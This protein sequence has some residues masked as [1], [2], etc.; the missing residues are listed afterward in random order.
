MQ[1]SKANWRLHASVRGRNNASSC[2]NTC[3]DHVVWR[4]VCYIFIDLINTRLEATNN[5]R[6][7]I[8]VSTILDGSKYFAQG[9]WRPIT[10]TCTTNIVSI[11]TTV[12]L[13]K[14]NNHFAVG[15][16]GE[17]GRGESGGRGDAAPSRNGQE[18][19]GGQLGTPKNPKKNTHINILSNIQ[20]R[21]VSL[22]RRKWL[23][24]NDL[25]PSGWEDETR[26]R[27]WMHAAMVC[28]PRQPPSAACGHV[29]AERGIPHTSLPPTP[30]KSPRS[31]HAPAV[32]PG[33]VSI[34]RGWRRRLVAS[35]RSHLN[36]EY[37]AQVEKLKV[38][39]STSRAP[40]AFWRKD[41]ALSLRMQ[42]ISGVDSYFT[43]ETVQ[44]V[45][46]GAA[47]M[48]ACLS[49]TRRRMSLNKRNLRAECWRVKG[50][51]PVVAPRA[52]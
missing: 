8:W 2:C 27:T 14:V 25:I 48:V 37:S 36:L 52:S 9:T 39:P 19:Q 38:R 21:H 35:K 6:C 50:A 26:R 20:S 23:N 1:F 51:P 4:N 22:I 3:S 45:S 18:D 12:M 40:F 32:L 49:K 11:A 5:K 13:F 15:A 44:H 7:G 16:K 41:I 10:S 34:A 42:H 31:E 33:W 24:E 28:L 43:L 46:S 29:R 17:R 30:C 47:T